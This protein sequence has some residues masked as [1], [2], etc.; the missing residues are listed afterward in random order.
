MNQSDFRMCLY[1]HQREHEHWRFLTT[2]SVRVRSA[3]AT[4]ATV[5]D[6]PLGHQS[7]E[8]ASKDRLCCGNFV[9]YLC[10]P[11]LTDSLYAWKGHRDSSRYREVVEWWDGDVGIQGCNVVSEILFY[12]LRIHRITVDKATRPLWYI[13]FIKCSK[14]WKIDYKTI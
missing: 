4:T 8:G 12:S 14:Y 10:S 9:K 2:P 1:Y 11:D 6:Y 3:P 5:S 13:I 7:A